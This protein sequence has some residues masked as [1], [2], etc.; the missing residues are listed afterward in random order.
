MPFEEI[1]HT[2]DW[3]IRVRAPDLA[4]LFSEAAL[5]MN[6]IGGVKLATSPRLEHAFNAN[7]LEPEGLLVLFLSE[8]VFQA[9]HEKKAFDHFNIS[10]TNNHLH[11]DMAGAPIQSMDKAIKAVTYH[12]LKIDET[13]DGL[14]AE[15]VFDV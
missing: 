12:N 2:A 14:I 1:R 6:E 11:V 15:I 4:S 9:E 7:S 10:I 13:H 3:S 5:G 8:L